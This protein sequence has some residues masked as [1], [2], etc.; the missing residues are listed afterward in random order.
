MKLVFC[1]PGKSYPPGLMPFL[2]HVHPVG[3]GLVGAGNGVLE[4]CINQHRPDADSSHEE[5][6]VSHVNPIIGSEPWLALTTNFAPVIVVLLPN[7]EGM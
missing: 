7:A 3:C 5:S 4:F 2:S 6:P 1:L